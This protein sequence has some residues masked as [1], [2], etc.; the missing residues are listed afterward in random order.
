MT[1]TISRVRFRAAPPD[2]VPRGL[3]GF[4]SLLVGGCLR[5]DGIAVRRAQCG[6]L[7]LSFPSRRDSHGTDH[8]YFRPIDDKSRRDVERQVLTALGMAEEIAP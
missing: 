7:V 1:L 4:V 5:L 3:I 2:Q 8:F 6:R